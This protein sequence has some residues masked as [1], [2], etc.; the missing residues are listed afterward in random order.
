MD[1]V[2]TWPRWFASAVLQRLISF[3]LNKAHLTG[4]LLPVFRCRIAPHR[5][6]AGKKVRHANE[7]SGRYLVFAAGGATNALF[8]SL[9]FTGA[10]APSAAEHNLT[11]ALVAGPP[12]P[13]S[14]SIGYRPLRPSCAWE[15][16]ITPVRRQLHLPGVPLAHR[17]PLFSLGKNPDK[18]T[19]KR[20]SR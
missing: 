17:K 15:R 14:S 3:I 11:P 10:L 4:D 2:P 5:L 7:F 13:V 20:V 19:A 6:L 9:S 12:C 1:S 18:R 8:Y 16:G